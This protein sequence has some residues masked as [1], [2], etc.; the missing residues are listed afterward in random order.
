M[1]RVIQSLPVGERIGIAFSGGLDT[2]VA[3]AWI[4]EEEGSRTRSRPISASTT[5]TM[6]PESRSVRSPTGPRRRSSSTAG[7]QLVHE[8][9][10]ALQCGAFH[11]SS[12][13]KTYF[14][15]TPLGRAVTGTMLVQA[16]R[17]HGVDIWGDGSTYKGNDIERFFRYGLSPTPPSASTSPG[18][19]RSS[20]PSSAAARR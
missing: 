11:I 14:N 7:E 5:R 9:L 3:V 15:T 18:S 20:S 10:V 17:E 13:G 12:A 16:M 1:S 6:S 19:I 8:G 2:S 4:R